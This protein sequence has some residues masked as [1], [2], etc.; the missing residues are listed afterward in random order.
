MTPPRAPFRGDGDDEPDGRE[1]RIMVVEDSASARRLLQQ[2]LLGLGVGLPDLRLAASVPEALQTF[3]QWTPAIVFVDLELRPPLHPPP[4]VPPVTDAMPK[5]G[6][7]LALE[8]LRRDPSTRLIV[9]SATDARETIV[10]D[11]VRAGR[12]QAIVKPLLAAKVKDVLDRATT[13]PP[14][15]ASRRR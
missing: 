5:D 13:A 11:L 6:A 9:C 12:I 1:R 15:P 8:L 3:A 14:S 2:L 10:G 7:E 4:G